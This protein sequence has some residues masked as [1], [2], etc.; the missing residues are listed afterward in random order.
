MQA[1]P[2]VVGIIEPNGFGRW[3]FPEIVHIDVLEAVHFGAKAAEHR[4]VGV[5]GIAGFVGGNAVVLK[6]SCGKVGGIIDQQAFA[7]RLHFMTGE[8]KLR[9]LGAIDVIHGAHPHA[10]KRQQEED[11]ERQDLSA[12]GC[13]HARSKHEYADQYRG[14][15]DQEQE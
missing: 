6:V 3:R 9:S 1:F 12:W 15:R 8:T 2:V 4:V 5:A 11:I 10:D 7:E 13:R 14:D